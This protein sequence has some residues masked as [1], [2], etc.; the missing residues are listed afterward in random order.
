MSAPAKTTPAGERR[1]GLDPVESAIAAIA[2]GK[3]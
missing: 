3:A 1:T 2:A